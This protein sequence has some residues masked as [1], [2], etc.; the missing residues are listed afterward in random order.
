MT[1]LRRVP[2]FFRALLYR[3]RLHAF[4]GFQ[5]LPAFYQ[6]SP[7]L[8]AVD[9]VSIQYAWDILVF[10]SFLNLAKSHVIHLQGL[11]CNSFWLDEVTYPTRRWSIVFFVTSQFMWCLGICQL[12]AFFVSPWPFQGGD[13][14]VTETCDRLTYGI[15]YNKTTV[16]VFQWLNCN[17]SYVLSMCGRN[18]TLQVWIYQDTPKILYLEAVLEAS[19]FFPKCVD[20][21]FVFEERQ[22]VWNQV[23]D[24]LGIGLRFQN[25][26]NL[27]GQSRSLSEDEK[28]LKLDQLCC[29]ECFGLPS[30]LNV[31][32]FMFIL[33]GMAYILELQKRLHSYK[34]QWKIAALEG[35]L[36][37]RK[38]IRGPHHA[39]LNHGSWN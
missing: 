17:Q 33:T 9:D 38:A 20:F 24:V 4:F 23:C 36:H 7:S 3:V 10:D 25:A 34:F 13:T 19:V 35:C 8:C 28:A 18:L 14:S 27:L 32:C 2:S 26:L 16:S 37:V 15:P 21:V 22:H 11:P 31:L 1:R 39:P 29:Y 12:Q 5:L 6:P 30:R